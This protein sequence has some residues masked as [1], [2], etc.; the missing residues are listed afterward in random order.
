MR[1]PLNEII[2]KYFFKEIKVTVD[3]GAVFEGCFVGIKLPSSE[4]AVMLYLVE[5]KHIPKYIKHFSKRWR[6]LIPYEMISEIELDSQA[7]P[8]VED[9]LI[10][11]VMKRELEG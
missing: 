4:R 8:E 5:T 6:I 1:I 3:T 2:R 11:A 7:L 10:T 9:A